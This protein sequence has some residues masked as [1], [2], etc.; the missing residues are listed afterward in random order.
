MVLGIGN[1]YNIVGSDAQSISQ[2]VNEVIYLNDGDY[3]LL[4]KTNFKIYDFNNNEVEREKINIKSNIN[5][6]NK[7]GYNNFMEK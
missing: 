5:F 2:M 1:G 7:D 4:N 3:A 6:L